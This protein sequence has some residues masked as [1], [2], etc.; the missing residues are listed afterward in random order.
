M[1]YRFSKVGNIVVDVGWHF[2]LN[3]LKCYQQLHIQP[4][5]VLWQNINGTFIPSIG[6]IVCGTKENSETLLLACLCS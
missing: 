3:I 1:Y 4:L 6:P 2:I 5:E